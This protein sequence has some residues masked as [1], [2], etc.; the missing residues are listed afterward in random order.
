MGVRRHVRT[1]VMVGYFHRMSWFCVKPC[2]ES[3]S[4]SCGFHS[5][6][7]TCGQGHTDQHRFVIA[8]NA[9]LYRCTI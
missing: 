4:F 1:L 3:S 6:A 7:H 2:D 9:I 8:C 5:S